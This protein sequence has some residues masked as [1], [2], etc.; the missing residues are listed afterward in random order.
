M[1]SRFQKKTSQKIPAISGT[2]TSLF[3]FQLL[4]SIG[5]P[6]IDHLLGG[7][8]PIGTVTLLESNPESVQQKAVHE[9]GQNF[10]Q[11]IIQYFIAEGSVYAHQLFL[12]KKSTE[13]IQIPAIVKSDDSVQSDNKNVTGEEQMK[14]AWRYESQTPTKEEMGYTRSHHFNLNKTQSADELSS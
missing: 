6:G 4:T 3:N 9:S 11:L 14:I 12:A 5:V 1:A 7:G 2:T 10:S 8:L 13:V